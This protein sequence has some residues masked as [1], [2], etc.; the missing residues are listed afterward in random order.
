MKN[1]LRSWR[2]VLGAAALLLTGLAA[3]YW[4]QLGDTRSV[5]AESLPARPDLGPLPAALLE[6]VAAA[7]QRAQNPWRAK[8][9]LVELSRLYHANG[10]YPEASQLYRGLIR[11]DQRSPRWPHFLA[12]ILAGFGQLDDALPHLRRVVEIAPDYIPAQLRLADALDKTNQWSEA[13]KIYATVLAR[14]PGN[15]YAL[16]GLARHN[17]N[18][19]NWAAARVQL[20]QIAEDQPKFTAAWTLLTTIDEHLGNKAA[21]ETDRLSER[22]SGRFREMPDPWLDE[23]LNE[24]YDSYRLDVAADAAGLSGDGATA[25]RLFQRAVAVAPDNSTAQRL[26]GNH[27][28]KADDLVSARVHLERAVALDP[29]EADN[30]SYLILLLNKVGDTE[31]S[32]RALTDG[33]A[34]CP[35]GPALHLEKGQR[36]AA[37]GRLDEALAEFKETRRLRP[38]EANSYVEIARIHFRL[39]RLEEGVAELREALKVDPDQPIALIL[40][41]RYAIATNDESAAR[42]WIRRARAQSKILHEDLTNVTTEYQQKFGRYP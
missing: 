41:A 30:W 32:G 39:N 28:L 26:L 2:I 10:F 8:A 9:A 11:L 6:R 1:S 22:R 35:Q 7:E 13:A 33:L 37:V 36:L 27:L 16:L 12:S 15:A 38:E 23:L 25:R 14:N 19:G 3:G 5:V 31:A 24:C 4:W 17:L 40:L 29:N 42:A 20:Q 34:H 21:A 18:I